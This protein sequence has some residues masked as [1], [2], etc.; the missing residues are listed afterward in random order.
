VARRARPDRG[1][2][3]HLDETRQ[4]EQGFP[5]GGIDEVVEG[6]LVALIAHAAHEREELGV[7]PLVLE[8]LEHHL[9]RR[10]QLVQAAGEEFARDV[11]ERLLVAERLLPAEAV[12]TRDQH[13]PGGERAVQEIGARGRAAARAAEEQFIGYDPRMAVEDGLAAEYDVLGGGFDR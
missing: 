9:A 4:F 7:R 8:D 13:L 3:V 1:R 12:E 2:D 10:Q 5:G 11:D 6:D